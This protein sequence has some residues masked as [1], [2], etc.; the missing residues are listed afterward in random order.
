MPVVDE[1][2]HL[3]GVIEFDDIIDIIQEESTEDINLLGE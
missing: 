1:M 3:L 2:D